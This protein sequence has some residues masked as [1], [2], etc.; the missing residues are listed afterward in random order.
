MQ[1]KIQRVGRQ[2]GRV[3]RK[4]KTLH[5]SSTV[6]RSFKFLQHLTIKQIIALCSF[7]TSLYV[8][9]HSGFSIN[10]QTMGDVFEPLYY[11]V[12]GKGIMNLQWY[13]RQVPSIMPILLYPFGVILKLFFSKYMV[14]FLLQ[15]IP[16]I[17]STITHLHLANSASAR[18]GKVV[19]H[20]THVFLS[21]NT[22]VLWGSTTPGVDLLVVSL[23]TLALSYWLQDRI[24]SMIFCLVIMTS[25]KPPLF[26]VLAAFVLEELLRCASTRSCPPKTVFV[27]QLYWTVVFSICCLVTMTFFDSA[28]HRSITS[29]FINQLFFKSHTRPSV[30]SLFWFLLRENTSFLLVFA[31]LSLIVCSAIRTLTITLVAS[32]FILHFTSMSTPTGFGFAVPYLSLCAGITLS[33]VGGFSTVPTSYVRPDE[34]PPTP[35]TVDLDTTPTNAEKIKVKQGYLPPRQ[36]N[37]ALKGPVMGGFVGLVLVVGF[38]MLYITTGLSFVGLRS[39]MVAPLKDGYRRFG[40]A[41]ASMYIKSTPKEDLPM[42]CIITL[43]YSSWLLPRQ[44]DKAYVVSFFDEYEEGAHGAPYKRFEDKKISAYIDFDK[45]GPKISKD[46]DIWSHLK[47]IETINQ[48]GEDINCDDVILGN[49]IGMILIQGQKRP[50]HKTKIQLELASQQRFKDEYQSIWN[51]YYEHYLANC[52]KFFFPTNEI[53]G[54][55][56][57]H[58]LSWRDRVLFGWLRPKAKKYMKQRKIGLVN[59]YIRDR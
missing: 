1:N 12:Y 5:R 33:R 34:T 29:S 50:S 10:Q 48:M 47:Q 26:L 59:F 45:G 36:L 38:A 9:L 49:R 39:A 32:C 4:I 21:F 11:M 35:D 30:L 20:L 55:D 37:Q 51:F 41:S 7:L 31:T 43:P 46:T 19:G 8:A 57:Y 3:G 24:P 2:L 53:R 44:C 40:P 16:A 25:L 15:V 18:F 14:L 58:S 22:F 13:Q 17:L 28:F 54:F 42:G 6:S 56:N 27:F 52:L 23:F